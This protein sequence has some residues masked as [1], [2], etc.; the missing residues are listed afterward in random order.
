MKVARSLRLISMVL[1]LKKELSQAKLGVF[2]PDIQNPCSSN[3]C[4]VIKRCQTGFTSK[5]YR[6]VCKNGLMGQNCTEGK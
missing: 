6:C 3:P 1:R 2:V 4:P 5:G